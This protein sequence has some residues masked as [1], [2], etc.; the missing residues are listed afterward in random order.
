M[1]P[2]EEQEK[3]CAAEAALRDGL[4][5]QH[6]EQEREGEQNQLETSRSRIMKLS[7]PSNKLQEPRDTRVRLKTHSPSA[8]GYHQYH[9]GTKT[10]R[11]T[12]IR[13][14]TAAFP[15]FTATKF[16]LYVVFLLS[17]PFPSSHTHF[18]L[19]L[20]FPSLL[21]RFFISRNSDFPSRGIC[22]PSCGISVSVRHG[23]QYTCSIRVYT[24]VYTYPSIF[25]KYPVYL[26]IYLG[27]C[28]VIPSCS[29][30][31]FSR[32]RLYI[33]RPVLML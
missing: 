31:F 6:A 23:Y 10:T 25:V 1:L 17:T 11:T 21:S 13:F 16:F 14:K 27:I 8:E 24:R 19:F 33:V 2:R 32:R 28:Q 20:L 30:D 29:Q 4:Y 26:G 15:L 22:F 9:A 7:L 12:A 18:Q 3:L 5:A